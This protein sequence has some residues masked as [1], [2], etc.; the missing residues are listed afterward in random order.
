V[1]LY[2]QIIEKPPQTVSKSAAE[3]QLAET[4]QAAGMTVDAKK[5]YEQ[6]QKEAPQSAAGQMASAK[7][8]ELK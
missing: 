8:Q 3:I 6:I 1:E 2:K 4:Y 5:Q 7:L